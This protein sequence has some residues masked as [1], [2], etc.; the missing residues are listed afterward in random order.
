MDVGLGCFGILVSGCG[1]FWCLG[2]WEE[3]VV[4]FVCKYGYRGDEDKIFFMRRG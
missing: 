3:L 4:D 2:L 1:I